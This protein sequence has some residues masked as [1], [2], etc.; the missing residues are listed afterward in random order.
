MTRL[1]YYVLVTTLGLGFILGVALILFLGWWQVDGPGKQIVSGRGLLNLTQMSFHLTDHEN[2]EVTPKSLEKK[3]SLIFFGFTWCP[4][5]CPTTLSDMSMWLDELGGDAQEL[6]AIFVSVDPERDT[7]SI[8][9]EYIAAFHPQIR[10]WTGTE[11][12]IS[13][14]VSEF[15][16]TVQKVQDTD[17]D[18]TIN[19]TASV[20]LFDRDGNFRSTV[21]FH[22]PR[23]VAVQKI[24]LLF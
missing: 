6:N 5:V 9:A 4:D 15:H 14:I 21:D 18:Y 19:H 2:Q 8:L 10:G 16:I 20:F 12:Q 7:P 23:A 17:T 13:Q 3:P 24:K 1:R 22:E 11:D